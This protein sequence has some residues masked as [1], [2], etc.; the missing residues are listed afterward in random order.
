MSR[1]FIAFMISAFII[2]GGLFF[3]TLYQ[4]SNLGSLTAN[5]PPANSGPPPA[6]PAPSVTLTI[7]TSTKNATLTITW[8]NLPPDTIA[9]DLYRTLK[10]KISWELW[11][12]IPITTST[13][14]GGSATF[15]FGKKE[16][17]ANYSFYIQAVSAANDHE[18]GGGTNNKG[19][20]IL[21]TSAIL[22]ATTAKNS[23]GGGGSSG[24][25][26]NGGSN[27]PT[28]T[29][30]GTPTNPTSTTNTPSTTN[31]TS[32]TNN[33]NN[34]QNNTSSNPTNNGTPPPTPSGTPY[35]TPEIK[36]SGY[37]QPPGGSFWVQ[38]VDEKIQIGWQ[39]LPPPT[40]EVE[41]MRSAG[42]TGPWSPVLVQQNPITQ[43][44]YSIQLVD[45]TVSQGYYY[46]LNDYSGSST[47]GTYGPIYLSPVG[48]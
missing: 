27:N 17:P 13:L 20:G 3:F 8:A 14:A 19:E 4:G 5:V 2:V 18:A 10:K 25:Q 48:Q 22:D 41:V 32:S 36:L 40:T 44:P 15:S 16:I 30:G 37:G 24:V 45:N 7:Q 29:G 23:S 28:N 33:P 11:H 1:S 39:N 34:P 31:S 6:P 35:Y 43:G 42:D 46:E 38:H 12:E 26:N 47:I 21:W 9:L